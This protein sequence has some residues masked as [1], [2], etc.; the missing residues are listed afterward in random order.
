MAER[1]G[2]VQAQHRA[3]EDAVQAAYAEFIEH[4]QECPPCRTDG[5]DCPTAA[6]LKQAYRNARDAAVAA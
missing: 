2:P 6:K 4:I 3:E 5:A 1:T